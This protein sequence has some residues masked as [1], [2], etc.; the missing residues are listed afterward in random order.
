[1]KNKELLNAVNDRKYFKKNKNL[2]KEGFGKM[3]ST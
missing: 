3:E 2:E 1:M